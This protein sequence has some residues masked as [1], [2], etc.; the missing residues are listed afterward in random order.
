VGA[1]R[2][3]TVGPEGTTLDL[4][5]QRKGEEKDEGA[6][7]PADGAQPKCARRPRQ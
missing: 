1:P 2:A 5:F 3:G 4:C 7:A 6:D